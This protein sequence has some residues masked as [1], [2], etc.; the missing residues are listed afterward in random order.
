MTTQE[1]IEKTKQLVEIPSTSDNSQALH[2]AVEF[3]ERIVKAECPDVIIEHFESNGKPSFLA[4][5]K[6]RRPKKFR[7]LLNG[8]VDVVP[9]N[10]K[11]FKP[12]VEDGK[13]YGR[14]ALDMK[15]TTLSLAKV[16][17]E[18]VHKV[19]Y[20]LALQVV[21]DEEI[22]GYDCVRVQ[23]DDGVRA[24]FVIAGEYSNNTD[25]IYNAARGLC[26]AEIA[27]KGKTSHGGHPWKGDNAVVKAGEFAGALL[28]R[29]PVPDKE[30]WTTTV[31]I[32][33][34][35]TPNQTF[36][37][38]PDLAILK[39]DFRFTQEDAVFEDRY[40]VE[41]FIKSIN[42]N[43]ELVNLAVFEPAVDVKDLNPYVRGLTAAMQKH[44]KRKVNYLG[45][46][47]GSDGRHFA[48][49]DVDIVEFGLY[50]QGE[51]SDKEY[52]ELASFEEYCKI[53]GSF[54]EK[55]VPDGT[56]EPRMSP[57]AEYVWYATFGTGLRKEH[58]IHSI[59]G[60]NSPEDVHKYVGC[61]DK[62]LP[63]KDEFISLPY[64]L[65]FSGVHPRS[66]NH[67]GDGCGYIDVMRNEMV[68]TISRAYLIT[69][70]QFAQIAAQENDY[71]GKLKMPFEQARK[72][73]LAT[74]SVD[75]A[76]N[77]LLYCG[78]K[79]GH[80][81]YSL[82]APVRGGLAKPSAFYMSTLC[83]GLSEAANMG[84]NEAISYLLNA[85]GVSGYYHKKDITELF[86]K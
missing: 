76:Y 53:V 81:M 85:P 36:N 60:E 37:K 74:L 77:G 38:V 13:L 19:P 10:E 59:T 26:W 51:H 58:F 42:P 47:A 66:H 55:P 21:C 48:L 73:G 62:T 45:R 67:D 41:E 68:H 24:D 50:G 43:A 34:L 16:F 80:P 7:I 65:Y 84:R 64:E 35:S 61:T 49:V 1:L 8:H 22:G 78:M 31:N 15:G 5:K 30:I 32:A 83:K 63:V 25:T 27:F 39:V 82:T 28:K 12:R 2:Q 69:K 75:G 20:D 11:Q 46:P 17:C 79:D 52:V 40:S 44:T 57:D 6:S 33:S 29:Y 23:I 86:E 72:D 14:G 4:Y 71:A 9:A 18:M 70:E 56:P 54:L 3:V